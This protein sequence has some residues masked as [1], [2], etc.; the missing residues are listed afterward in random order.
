MIKRHFRK[1]KRLVKN[2]SKVRYIPNYL[3]RE[4][5]LLRGKTSKRLDK[6]KCSFTITTISEAKRVRGF[7]NEEN[8]I[9]EMVNETD[10]SD[11]FYDIGANIGTHSCFVG[12]DRSVKIYAFEPFSENV[13]S[14]RENFE[15]NEIDGELL[16]IALMNED[17]EMKISPES[18]ESGEGEVHI[19]DEGKISVPTYKG[20]TIIKEKDL[21]LPNVIKI[22]VEGAEFEVLKGLENTLESP[23]CRTI[24]LEIHPDRMPNFGGSEH[25]LKKFLKEKGF[26]LEKLNERSQEIHIKANREKDE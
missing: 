2:P 24:F 10:D 4:F 15:L 3:K 13:K 25:E 18:G 16:E 23:E 19:S 14:L 12:K 6:N 5:T 11:V 22:D 26:S 20:D 1:I 17:S 21:D 8:V 7:K 9:H